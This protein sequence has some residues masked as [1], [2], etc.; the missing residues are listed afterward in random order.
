[1]VGR[2]VKG[3]SMGGGLASADLGVVF[4]QTDQAFQ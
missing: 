1:M 2:M 4:F 3:T